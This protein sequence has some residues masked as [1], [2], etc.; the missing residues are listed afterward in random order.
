MLG[1]SPGGFHGTRATLRAAAASCAGGA[2]RHRD[3]AWACVRGAVDYEARVAPSGRV[4]VTAD[5][6]LAA[7]RCEDLVPGTAYT[8]N[9]RALSDGAV[10]AWAT[11]RSRRPTC[12]RS[13]W[14]V[15]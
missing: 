4:T 12:R 9:V 1:A 10:G 3:A 6:A 7:L 2:R 11:A 15:R 8:V 13:R 5:G 14:W